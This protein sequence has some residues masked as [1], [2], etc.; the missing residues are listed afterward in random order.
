[1]TKL[2]LI[3][4][5]ETDWNAERRFQGQADRAL[6]ETGLAQAQALAECIATLPETFS[7]L[8]AS[9]L[10]RTMQTAEPLAQKLNLTVQTV[11]EIIEINCGQWEGMIGYEIDKVYHGE[12]AAWRANITTYPMPGGES[13]T[14]MQQRGVPFYQ[15]L[16]QDHPDD[17]VLI[18]GHGA[19]LLAMMCHFMEW[20]LAPTWADRSKRLINVGLSVLHLGDENIIERFNWTGDE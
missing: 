15:R 4:H 2:Y 3:R 18:V 5:G 10:K 19:S 17:A 1:M 8:Y 14:Q 11:P 16:T 7:T 12:L 13:V 20:E 9:P 6:N